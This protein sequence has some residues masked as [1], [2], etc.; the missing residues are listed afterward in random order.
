MLDLTDVYNDLLPLISEDQRVVAERFA[1]TYGARHAL[2]YVD[3]C[4]GIGKMPKLGRDYYTVFSLGTEVLRAEHRRVKRWRD[5]GWIPIQHYRANVRNVSRISSV[6]VGLF[7]RHS[8]PWHAWSTEQIIQPELRAWCVRCRERHPWHWVSAQE[9]ADAHDYKD[10]ESIAVRCRE[11]II[12]SIKYGNRHY[13]RSDELEKWE[14]PL[15]TG[16]WD[17]G[18]ESVVRPSLWIPE[19]YAEHVKMLGEGS[20]NAGVVR[21]I[22]E[23]MGHKKNA[24]GGTRK[25]LQEIRDKRS[26][27][28]ITYFDTGD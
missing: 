28:K 15:S 12:K 1:S 26:R 2:S 25:T 9:A 4:L 27:R 5:Y 10:S 23:D 19:S 7:L 8:Y 20:I 24:P 14:G 21:L 3:N 13:I 6:D 11:G 17:W 16:K 18:D 22:E